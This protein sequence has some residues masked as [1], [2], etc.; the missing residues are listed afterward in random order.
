MMN[1]GV[2]IIEVWILLPHLAG[3]PWDIYPQHCTIDLPFRSAFVLWCTQLFTWNKARALQPSAPFYRAIQLFF[4]IRCLLADVQ[5]LLCRRP[6][7][8]STS[9]TFICVIYTH[10]RCVHPFRHS[11]APSASIV[12]YFRDRAFL[13]LWWHV[14][15]VGISIVCRHRTCTSK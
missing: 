1:Q 3:Y 5:Q 2:I 13:C 14:C 7:C 11:P 4:R 10:P 8:I 6:W 15:C 9:L 12:A